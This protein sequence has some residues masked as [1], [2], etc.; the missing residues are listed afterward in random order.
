MLKAPSNEYEKMRAAIEYKLA[1]QA[2]RKT[3]RN[4]KD[5]L[6]YDIVMEVANI[7]HSM[8][9]DVKRRLSEDDTDT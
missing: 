8:E 5:K 2:I 6:D 4:G 9:E 7:I 3:I 1:L